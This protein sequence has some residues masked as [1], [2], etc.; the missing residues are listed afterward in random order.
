LHQS[1]DAFVAQHY[2]AGRVLT[3][4]PASDELTRPWLGY[5]SQAVPIVRIEDF[6]AAQILAAADAR[7]SY[8]AA[9]VFSTKYEPRHQLR[10]PGWERLQERFFGYHHDLPPELIARMLGARVLCDQRLGQQWVAVLEVESIENA[11]LE[12][13]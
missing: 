2:P 5:V 6:S 3:A 9:L 12:R 7:S 1:A 10:M 13:F 11:R 4:W 8:R